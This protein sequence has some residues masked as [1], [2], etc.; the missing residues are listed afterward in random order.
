M[1]SRSEITA[2]I[3]V[4]DGSPGRHF[5]VPLWSV[6]ESNFGDKC[7]VPAREV[8]RNE[9]VVLPSIESDVVEQLRVRIGRRTGPKVDRESR[10]FVRGMG[11]EI[12]PL[13]WRR[14]QWSRNCLLR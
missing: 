8:S 6:G 4:I 5:E 1:K 13:S 3:W 7:V 12:R 14:W 2:E 11:E 10:A 9:T